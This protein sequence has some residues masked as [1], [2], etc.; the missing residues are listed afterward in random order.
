MDQYQLETDKKNI[1]FFG[2]HK[3]ATNWMR[4]VLGDICKNRRWCLK[5]YGGASTSDL[6]FHDADTVFHCFWNAFTKDMNNLPRS[7][8][9]F[10]LIRD[11]RDAVVSAYW[12]WKNTHGSE[13]SPRIERERQRLDELNLEEG[14]LYMVERIPLLEQ[15]GGWDPGSNNN[16]LNVQYEE[17]LADTTRTYQQVFSFL[18]Q[19]FTEDEVNALVEKHSFERVTGRKPG[20]ED[21]N[22]HFRKGIAGDWKNYFTGNIRN[23]F[24]ER[25]G[26][27][28]IRLGYE[29]DQN[30]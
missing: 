23:L 17:L 24:K 2:H 22:H 25:Y 12:S 28:L 16:I 29:Q 8:R 10:H 20:T 9:G 19:N 6:D 11:P 14:L 18:G 15:L 21:T 5:G 4:M 26:E 13:G 3:C 30:W 1:F 7:F 27:D